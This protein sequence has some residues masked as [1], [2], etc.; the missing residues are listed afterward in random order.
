MKQAEYNLIT[1]DLLNTA[2]GIADAKRPAYTVGSSDVLAN[3]KRV[4]GHSGM[5]VGQC[6]LVYLLKHLDSIRAFV[7]NEDLPQDEPIKTRYA[8]LINYVLLNYCIMVE[9]RALMPHFLGGAKIKPPEAN[10]D[11]ENE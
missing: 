11:Q 3:F 1:Q 5:S 9:E 6:N 7:L 10:G 2:Q 8:D 4:A